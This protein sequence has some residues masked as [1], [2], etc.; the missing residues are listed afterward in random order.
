[1]SSNI[2]AGNT[3]RLALRIAFLDDPANGERDGNAYRC[4]WGSLQ[5]WLGGRN[6]C[7]HREGGVELDAVHWYLLPMLQWL[8]ANWEA[9]LHEQRLPN[10]NLATDAWTCLSQTE[11]C[12]PRIEGDERRASEWE[13]N[14]HSW[15]SRHALRA[16]RDGGI[17]PDLVL[18]RVGADIE[19]SWGP[20]PLAGVPRE[21]CFAAERGCEGTDAA[22]VA[23]TLYDVMCGASAALLAQCPNDT[24]AKRLSRQIAE[25]PGRDKSQSLMWLVGLGT[26]AGAVK[27]GWNKLSN[28]L[29]RIPKGAAS[30]MLSAEKSPLVTAGSCQAAML[31]GSVAPN[32]KE[33]DVL[34]LAQAVADLTGGEPE[35][36]LLRNM[37]TEQPLV[38]RLD[39]PVWDQGYELATQVHGIV[40]ARYTQ[41]GCFDVAA[42]LKDLAVDV[43]DIRLRDADIRGVAIAGPEHHP[44]IRVNQTHP[45]NQWA[46]GRRFTLAHELCHLLHDRMHGKRLA[47]AS[48]SWAPPGVEQRANAFAAALLMPKSLIDETLA[49]LGTKRLSGFAILSKAAQRLQV[50]VS[51]LLAHIEN[52]D[53]IDAHTKFLIEKQ[54][55]ESH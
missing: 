36:K 31:Y 18:R 45:A 27:R 42:L 5:I 35:G 22:E 16:V 43:A 55:G 23:K 44:G 28:A 34:A 48:G 54:M 25:I 47:L 41:T 26:T 4:S 7:L 1:M 13:R 33:P 24:E 11:F 19:F 37:V 20:R 46:W 12:P 39:Y 40:G 17:F 2:W 3:S 15:W 9:L 30:T 14:W 29:A 52:T 6:L 51:T 32:L 38:W 50:S 21:F 8:G 53:Y 10:S 49:K